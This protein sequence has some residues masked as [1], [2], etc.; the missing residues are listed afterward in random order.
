VEGAGA[1]VIVNMVWRDRE[2]GRGLIIVGVCLDQALLCDLLVLFRG[3]W[4]GM[5][6]G[7]GGVHCGYGGFIVAGAICRD[8]RASPFAC[9]QGNPHVCP[10]IARVMP[11]GS[12]S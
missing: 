2:A 8:K 11:H 9:Q 4:G 6:A 7:V 3:V 5:V 12:S 10:N 1:W